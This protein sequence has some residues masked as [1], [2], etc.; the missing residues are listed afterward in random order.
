[1]IKYYYK[2]IRKILREKGI[3]YHLYKGKQY[4]YELL[5]AVGTLMHNS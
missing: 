4:G 2:L 3:I 1:M 5:K